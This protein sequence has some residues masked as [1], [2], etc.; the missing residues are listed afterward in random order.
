[1][2]TFSGYNVSVNVVLQGNLYDEFKHFTNSF[3]SW[4]LT[5]ERG[6]SVAITK[7]KN[8]SWIIFSRSTFIFLTRCDSS[9]PASSWSEKT[10]SE[11]LK[12]PFSVFS[13]FVLLFILVVCLYISCLALR[14]YAKG[15]GPLPSYVTFSLHFL[16]IIK[17]ASTL[18]SEDLKWLHTQDDLFRNFL[19]RFFKMNLKI[20]NEFLWEYL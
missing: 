19:V 18:I 7:S 12:I 15:V 20:L 4:L 9:T 16:H 13:L 3:N 17:P 2:I 10:E 5:S 1:M 11:S 8:L 6:W 14:W